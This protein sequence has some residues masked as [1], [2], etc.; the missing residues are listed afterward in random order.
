MLGR[1][2]EAH[3]LT[4]HQACLGL[5]ARESAEDNGGDRKQNPLE[6]HPDVF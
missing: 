6:Q 4:Q 5:E 3:V 1:D 2:P